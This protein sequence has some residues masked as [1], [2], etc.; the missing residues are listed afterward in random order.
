MFDKLRRARADLTTM[1]TLFPAAERIAQDD[2]IERLGAEHLLLGSLDLNDDIAMS[3]LSTFDVNGAELRAAIG[4]QHDEALSSIGVIAADDS[5]AA[6]LP[7]AGQ[8]GGPYR[9]KGSLQTAFQRAVALATLDKAAL[10]SG[11]ILLAVTEAGHGTVV[12]TLRHL[13]ISPT[14]LHDRTR[15]LLALSLSSGQ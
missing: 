2:G 3:V 15:Q 12:R 10:N 4:A 9:S 6:A 1:N 7:A 5:I 8:M 11:Y 13:G 14:V